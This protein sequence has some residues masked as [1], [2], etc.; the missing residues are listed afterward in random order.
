MAKTQDEEREPAVLIERRKREVERRLD[1]TESAA[2]VMFVWLGWPIEM[3]E[4]WRMTLASLTSKVH[5]RLAGVSSL[6]LLWS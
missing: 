3:T 1:A 6:L 2:C 5:G 4:S